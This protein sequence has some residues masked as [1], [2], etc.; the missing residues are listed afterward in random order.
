MVPSSLCPA[1]F[2]GIA[3]LMAA[4]SLF[5]SS[6]L[7][8]QTSPEASNNPASVADS[9]APGEADPANPLFEKLRGSGK[10]GMALFVISVVGFSFAF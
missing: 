9:A 3:L 10:T 1:R 5:F 6:S 4:A 7:L 2:I 8:A